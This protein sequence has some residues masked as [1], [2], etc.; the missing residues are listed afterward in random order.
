MPL[1]TG[2]R[3]PGR[4]L[5]KHTAQTETGG[6]A[7]GAGLRLVCNSSFLHREGEPELQVEASEQAKC[8]SRP[9]GTAW[10]GGAPS[11]L[12]PTL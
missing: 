2:P 11:F 10:E 6:G 5:A 9:L 4:I 1:E 8:Q 12:L 3:T 7:G